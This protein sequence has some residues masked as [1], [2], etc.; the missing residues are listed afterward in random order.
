[1]D[2]KRERKAEPVLLGVQFVVCVVTWAFVVYLLEGV[3]SD[4]GL[5]ASVITGVVLV[6][7]TW[8]LVKLGWLR[9]PERL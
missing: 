5:L 1:M 9:S 3:V 6:V 2:W 4:S 8:M 7:I